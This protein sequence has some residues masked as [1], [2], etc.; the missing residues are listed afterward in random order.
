MVTEDSKILPHRF[1]WQRWTVSPG[2]CII[3]LCW[4]PESDED[5]EAS[6]FHLRMESC[7]KA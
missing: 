1:N 6:S 5:Q 3:S 2:K 7:C 4:R